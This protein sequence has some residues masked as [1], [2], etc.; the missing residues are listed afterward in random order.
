MAKNVIRKN[1]DM[2]LDEV[3]RQLRTNIEFSQMD[4]TLRSI[5]VLSTNPNEG[6]SS[7]SL[8]LAKILRINTRRFF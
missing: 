5:N 6:K 3:Y 8:N 2:N 7:V 4:E 1:D